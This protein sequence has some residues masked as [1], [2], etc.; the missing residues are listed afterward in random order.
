MSKAEQPFERPLAY[1]G[2]RLFLADFRRPRGGRR[3]ELPN[4]SRKPAG[5][6]VLAERQERSPGSALQLSLAKWN[7]TFCLA[8][9]RAAME[10]IRLI[11]S[12]LPMKKRTTGC[13]RKI[14]RCSR[15]PRPA[16]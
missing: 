14:A 10:E 7:A 16:P 5:P 8:D 3:S 2:D 15:L 6:I 4:P 13:F 9:E 12:D 11:L 1:A